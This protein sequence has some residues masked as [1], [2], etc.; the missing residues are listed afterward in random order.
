[1]FPA[2][3]SVTRL[4][5]GGGARYGAFIRDTSEKQRLHG[6]LVERERLATLGLSASVF[7]HEVGNPLHNLA[8]H[9]QLL[10]R[11]LW[12]QDD[13]LARRANVIVDEVRRLAGLLEE[14]RTFGRHQVLELAP[15]DVPALL[16]E[17]VEMKL[18][19]HADWN[20]RITCDAPDGLPP[21][22]GHRDKLKQVLVNLCKNA[23]DAMPEGGRLSL[24]ARKH[25]DVLTLTV[26]DTAGGLPDGIDVF[27]PFQSTKDGGLGLGLPIV[28]Q[29]VEAHGGAI[30]HESRPGVGTRFIVE[31]PAGTGA[32]R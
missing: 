25:G 29:I 15:V 4:D 9:A 19:D 11:R 32:P 31:L 18:G 8:L 23:L 22:E 20:V 10:Q 16:H 24:A 5:A 30:R 13:T 14:F 7:A 12:R 26:E 17:V 27:Q 3:L 21:I 1:V 28:R 6:E 2:E